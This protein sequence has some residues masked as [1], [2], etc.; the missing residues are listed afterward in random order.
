MSAPTE[1][2]APPDADRI[3]AETDAAVAR[4]GAARAAG[5]P[6]VAVGFGYHDLPPHELGADAVIGHFDELVP[7]LE[8]L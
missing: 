2:I 5:I 6:V 3:V 4:I 8:H 1:T 7:A